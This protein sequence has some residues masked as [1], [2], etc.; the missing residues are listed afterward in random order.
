MN[1]LYLDGATPPPLR[2][3]KCSACH[4]VAF[5]PNPYG[6]E[7]CGAPASALAEHPL[8]G[9]GQLRAFATTFVPPRKDMAAP[10]TV[11]SIALKDGPVVRALMTVPTDDSLR[12]GGAVRSVLVADGSAESG[13]RMQLRF[14][15]VE[16]A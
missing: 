10:F 14:E 2:G 1:D 6:C 15:P 8:E 4:A 7:T 13:P 9:R 12:I 5:P 11:A 3:Q 16:Q